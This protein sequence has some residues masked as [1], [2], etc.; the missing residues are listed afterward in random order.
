[1]RSRSIS[2]MPYFLNSA[3]SVSATIGIIPAFVGLADAWMASMALASFWKSCAP[4]CPCAGEAGN[5]A[6]VDGC[7]EKIAITISATASAKP[8]P[9]A[10]NSIPISTTPFMIM[11]TSRC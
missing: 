2:T 9:I 7:H 11:V 3:A 4:C 1:M 5:A 8:S 10:K 6:A